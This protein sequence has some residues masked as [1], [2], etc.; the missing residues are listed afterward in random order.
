MPKIKNI[1]GKAVIKILESLGFV[2]LRQKGSH[3]TLKRT[4]SNIEQIIL[5]PNH[6]TIDRGTLYS[7]YKKLKLYVDESEIKSYFYTE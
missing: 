1:S 7:I 5:V 6:A 3:V 4:V 2:L